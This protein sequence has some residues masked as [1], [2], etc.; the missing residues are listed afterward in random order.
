MSHVE[1]I[2]GF[3]RKHKKPATAKQIAEA[4]GLTVTTA[5]NVLS[6]NRAFFS[7]TGWGT[8]HHPH[9]WSQRHPLTETI[10]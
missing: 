6:E 8:R 5:R 9:W 7:R 10:P 2:L 4:T 3:L 1:T